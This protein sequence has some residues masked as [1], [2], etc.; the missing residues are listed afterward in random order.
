MVHGHGV[1]G[2]VVDHLELLVQQLPHVRVQAVDQRVAVVFPCVI[3]Q[4]R[5]IG[6]EA[7]GGNLGPDS[8][9]P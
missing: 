6:S 3:L 4:Q 5:D 8:G 2:Q 1:V 9:P 7:P